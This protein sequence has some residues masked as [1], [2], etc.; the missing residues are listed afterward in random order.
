M[1]ITVILGRREIREL[2]VKCD[3]AEKDCPWVGTVGRLEEHVGVCQRTLVPCLN[4]CKGDNGI[5]MITKRDLQEH[6]EKKCPNRDYS[7]EHCDLKGTYATTLDHYDTC[8]K[9]II[10]CTNEGCTMKMKRK[11]IKNHLSEECEHTV[12][13]CKYMNIGCDAKLKRKDMRA[14]EKA[15]KALITKVETFK[16]TGFQNKKDNNKKYFSPS[17]YTYPNGYCMKIELYANGNGGG[18]R[19]YVSVY[20]HIEKGEYD[21]ALKWP[22][23][24]EVTIELLNQLE[25]E[26]H[27]SDTITF[28]PDDNTNA[29]DNWGRPK[30][31]PHSELSRDRKYNTQYLKGNTL[32]FK[33]TVEVTDQKHWLEC[34]LN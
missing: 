19:S 22:F 2:P 14:H 3:N 26:N 31:I 20:A 10:T 11:K 18:K 1:L 27:Y 6:L 21:N 12:I 33:I 7:C 34:T 23:V 32:N 24:G 29:G 9:K 4:E 15:H 13:T 28:T 25:N 17:F 8:E 16:V 5:L 30:Y